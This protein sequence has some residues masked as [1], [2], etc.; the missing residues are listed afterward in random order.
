MPSITFSVLPILSEAR[1]G[2]ILL[3]CCTRPHNLLPMIWVFVAD[4]LIQFG[5]LHFRPYNEVPVV[6]WP[7]NICNCQQKNRNATKITWNI[8]KNKFGRW[9]AVWLVGHNRALDLMW[10]VHQQ[11]YCMN[12][13]IPNTFCLWFGKREVC[14]PWK[15]LFTICENT[16]I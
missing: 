12:A 7:L 10:C 2:W 3:M 8:C 1:P 5:W 16:H 14:S 4:A 9:K 13:D 6:L 15:V 11:K